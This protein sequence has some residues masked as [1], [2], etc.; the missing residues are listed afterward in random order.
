MNELTIN[1]NDN[2]ANAPE[3]VFNYD[4]EL[5]TSWDI[6]SDEG[7]QIIV[8]GHGLNCVSYRSINIDSKSHIRGALGGQFI[9]NDGRTITSTDV[10]STRAGVINKL[11]KDAG[12]LDIRYAI[13]EVGPTAAGMELYHLLWC[14]EQEHEGQA[15][16]LSID[17]DETD[18]SFEVIPTR[19]TTDTDGL[20]II[21][22]HFA[23][24]AI[25]WFESN[26]NK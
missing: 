5:P 20:F 17:S 6:I 7:D 1:W 21:A 13:S 4:C 23:D 16:Q 3:F 19:D 11:V 10:W 22:E 14:L 26:M 15:V 25:A 8:S 18:L 24:E 2:V 9:L 12:K